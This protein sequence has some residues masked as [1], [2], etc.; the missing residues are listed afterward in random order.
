MRDDPRHPDPGFAELYGSLPDAAALEPWL[1]LARA[2][3]PPV[4]YLGAGAGRLAAPRAAAG[5]ELVLVD[6][7]PGMVERLRRRLPEVEVHQALIEELRLARRFDL[8]MVP[9]NILDRPDLLAAAADH[10]APGGRLAFELTNPHWLAAGAQPGYRVLEMTRERAR[11][12]VDYPGGAVQEGEI[13]LVWPEEIEDFLA[14]AGL[15]LERM[16][17]LPG[18]ELAESAVFYV[19]AV[20]PRGRRP[21]PGSGS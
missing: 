6:A 2:A 10:L 4:L 12:E 3:R 20:R 16:A 15:R 11:V 21:P 1:G 5:V 8:V 9:S 14:G 13:E 18:A 17:G 7:H 19:V